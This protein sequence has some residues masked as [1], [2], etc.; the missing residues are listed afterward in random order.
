[1]NQDNQ[2]NIQLTKNAS[3]EVFF[4]T[5]LIDKFN[6]TTEFVFPD[7]FIIK[8]KGVEIASISGY[9]QFY[10]FTE[11]ILGYDEVYVVVGVFKH[12]HGEL[13][14]VGIRNETY[15]NRVVVGDTSVSR[16][17][18]LTP[19]MSLVEAGIDRENNKLII[20]E[21]GME[22][23]TTLYDIPL[24]PFYGIVKLC[25]ANVDGIHGVVTAVETEDKGTEVCFTPEDPTIEQT[26]FTASK[27][28]KFEGIAVYSG[29]RLVRFVSPSGLIIHCEFTV[30]TTDVDKVI[31][32]LDVINSNEYF[33]A[34][35]MNVKEDG[36]TIVATS[37]YPDIVEGGPQ[38]YFNSEDKCWC[39][40]R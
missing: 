12:I 36:T 35:S 18:Q 40:D 25:P 11:E 21:G 20:T 2:T 7:T 23:C 27:H 28:F 24:V 22:T 15:G 39:V 3:H 16:N 5:T 9:T 4:G 37:A 34:T 26:K 32:R 19:M 6:F 31:M 38:W 8:L 17:K 13:H 10:G 29:V 33:A 14:V 30:I 1:M